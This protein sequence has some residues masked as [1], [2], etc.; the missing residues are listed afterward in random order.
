MTRVTTLIDADD[1]TWDHKQDRSRSDSDSC[2]YRIRPPPR[3]VLLFEINRHVADRMCEV[4]I[5]VDLDMYVAAATSG[6][7]SVEDV[8]SKSRYHRCVSGKVVLQQQPT[9]GDTKHLA[10][11]HY[12][13]FYLIQ[14]IQICIPCLTLQWYSIIGD[15]GSNI[16]FHQN[17]FWHPFS[18]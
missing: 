12:N 1:L 4:K 13:Y 14:E 10:R 7:Y 18:K 6:R 3:S 15:R 9:I 8:P 16:D 11:P 2:L 5:I 17:L